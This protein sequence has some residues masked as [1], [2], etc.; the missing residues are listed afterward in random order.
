MMWIAF[1]FVIVARAFSEGQQSTAQAVELEA[2]AIGA[3][4]T[5]A[6]AEFAYF[7]THKKLACK[8]ADLGS[9]KDGSVGAQSAGLI[10]DD[11]ASGQRNG[12]QYSIRCAGTGSAQISASPNSGIKTH[13]FCTE[14]TSNGKDADGGTIHYSD[15][16]AMCQKQGKI[17]PSA[18]TPVAMETQAEAGRRQI[19]QLLIQNKLPNDK[20]FF[21]FVENSI[22]AW[23]NSDQTRIA[24]WKAGGDSATDVLNEAFE[25]V[26]KN[27][28]VA[29]KTE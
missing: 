11:L 4:R 23:I 19:R 12:Y 5:L 15:T 16:V 3:M 1:L 6:T 7:Y 26:M 24:R 28:N 21:D 14:I 10:Y 2:G 20:E 18:G 25:H 8:L 9:S 27:L 29:H 13:A 22:A 17:L